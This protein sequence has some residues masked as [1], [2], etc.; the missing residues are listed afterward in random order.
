MHHVGQPIPKAGEYLT[1]KT[2][3]T[4]MQL[5]VEYGRVDNVIE[6]VVSKPVLSSSISGA[7]AIFNL[8]GT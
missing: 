1:Q 6:F 2:L 7:Y 3:A 4:K 5:G 8:V